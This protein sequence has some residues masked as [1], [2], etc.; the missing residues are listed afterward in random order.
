[1][2]NIDPELKEY[3]ERNILPLYEAH[4]KA[5]GPEDSG[6][7][8]HIAEYPGHT[9]RHSSQGLPFQPKADGGQ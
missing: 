7:Q 9:C 1:M 3:M 8:H 4:D 2:W 5:H 6:G